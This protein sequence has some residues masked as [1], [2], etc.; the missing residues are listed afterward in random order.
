M[1]YRVEVKKELCISSAKC[2][3]DAPKIFKFDQ[4]ELA[5]PVSETTQEQLAVLIRLARNCP[6]EAIFIYDESGTVV[7]LE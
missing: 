2:V 7:N 3:S 1:N 6:S 5:E 4:D